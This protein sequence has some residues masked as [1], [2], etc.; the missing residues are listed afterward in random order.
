M[1][2]RKDAKIG[3]IFRLKS[4]DTWIVK[5]PENNFLTVLSVDLSTSFSK[6]TSG[7]SPAL[8][9]TG[10]ENFSV[11]VLYQGKPAKISKRSLWLFMEEVV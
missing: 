5:V 6:M 4:P 1:T 10:N 8:I 11:K 3:K 7:D 9:V 2:D